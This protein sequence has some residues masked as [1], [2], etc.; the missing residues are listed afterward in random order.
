MTLQG[1]K[2]LLI[3]SY[4]KIVTMNKMWKECHKLKNMINISKN[5]RKMQFIWMR[6]MFFVAIIVGFMMPGMIKIDDGEKNFYTIYLNESKIGATDSRNTIDEVM[7][8]ARR[9]IALL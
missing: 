3:C 2:I 7:A 6:V 1:K 4:Y 5:Y 9:I 8:H